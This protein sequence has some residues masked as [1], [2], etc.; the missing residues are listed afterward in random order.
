MEGQSPLVSRIGA[1]QSLFYLMPFFV[2]GSIF[3]C[4]SIFAFQYF[5]IGASLIPY[6]EHNDANRALMSSNMQRQAV[7]LSQSDKCIVGTGLEGQAALDSGALTIAEHEGKIFYTDTNKI[8]L[9]GNGDTLRIPLVMY[10]RSNKN[11]CMHQKPQVRRG[12]CIKKGQ[13]LAYGAATVGGELALG[14]NVLVA[15]MPWE[16]YNFEDAVLISECLVYEDIY[17]SFH[18]RKYEIQ[19]NQGPE[20]VT[21]EIPHLKVHLLR[22]LDKNG[23]VMQ[24]VADH[25]LGPATDHRLGKLLPHQ[26]ANQTRAPPRAD[27]S[28]C[29]SAYGAAVSSCCSPPKGRFPI[30][31]DSGCD[32]V[33]KDE[34]DMDSSNKIS[35]LNKNQFFDLFHLFHDRNRGGYTLHHD[36]ESEERFQE[37]TDFFTLSITK[38]DPV[39]H[40]RFAFS[41]DSY[42][43][44]PKEFLNGVFN[45]RSASMFLLYEYDLFW[46]VIRRMQA[47]SGMIGRKASVGG[48]LSPPS[49]PRAQLWTGGGN[50]QA[51]VREESEPRFPD[52]LELADAYSPDTVI[53]SSSGKEVH[54]PWAFYLH[55]ALL[56]QAFAH[57]RKFPTAASRRSL[58]RVSVPMWLIILSDQLLIIALK[59]DSYTDSVYSKD[60]LGTILTIS[61]RFFSEFT[62]TAIFYGIDPLLTVQEYVELNMS[63]STGERSFADIITSIRYWV[64]H[65]ITIPSLFIA[66]WLFVSTGLAYD[67]FGSP[68]PNE[69]FTE[70]RQGIPLITSRFDSLEQLD[71]FSRSF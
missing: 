35:F 46:A 6:I 51:G 1:S 66:G 25:P 13:I 17:T 4:R 10:Q 2:H 55:V 64:I 53:A 37:M 70:N 59:K 45:S 27:S 31:L 32:M 20:T 24:C 44:D 60:A 43:L 26:L 61:Q 36:F 54:D 38:P 63:G 67:V 9:S 15:Y 48:F 12:K 50:Y 58:G 11:T 47:L 62:F 3:W 39:Y 8:L 71:E 18:I 28:F 22:N 42:G 57:C 49:N 52:E 68:R 40:K 14:K 65:S 69:Y 23:I 34:P 21:N 33:P 16:G 29:S 41:I 30:S 19:I 5:S 56:R 7:P